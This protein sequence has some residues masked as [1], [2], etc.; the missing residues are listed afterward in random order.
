MV[1]LVETELTGRSDGCMM[2]VSGDKNSV[3]VIVKFRFFF[4][5]G[6]TSDINVLIRFSVLFVLVLI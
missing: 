6:A 1:S 4:T 2:S 5:V 3:T